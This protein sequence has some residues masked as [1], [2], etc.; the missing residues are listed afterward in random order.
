MKQHNYVCTWELSSTVALKLECMA[1]ATSH[2]ASPQSAARLAC[3][4]LICVGVS[5]LRVVIQQSPRKQKAPPFVSVFKLLVSPPCVLALGLCCYFVCAA[6]CVNHSRMCRS[7]LNLKVDKIVV[8]VCRTSTP[9]HMNGWLSS[10]TDF[11]HFERRNKE[12]IGMCR[13][14]DLDGHLEVDNLM[15]IRVR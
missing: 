12:V 1:K 15:K 10:G 9:F 13:C 5:F 3:S 8:C 14:W 11:L 4:N 2:P 6:L 7:V